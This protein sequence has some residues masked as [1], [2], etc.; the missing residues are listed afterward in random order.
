MEENKRIEKEE[1]KNEIKEKNSIFT[2]ILDGLK[3]I[4]TNRLVLILLRYS[5][6]YQTAVGFA[7]TAKR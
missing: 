1:S 4:R 6:S 7:H 2:D 3:Y 5:S